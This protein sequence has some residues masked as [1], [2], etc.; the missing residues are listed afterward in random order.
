MDEPLTDEEFEKFKF[1]FGSGCGDLSA[2]IT[3]VQSLEE[4]LEKQKGLYLSA[5]KG[6][7][8]MRAAL[9][10]HR[11]ENAKLKEEL[12]ESKLRHDETNNNLEETDVIAHALHKENARLK[13]MIENGVGFEDLRDDH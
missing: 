5:V 8:D 13:S 4:E 3:K 12:E 6:R 2:V 10:M 7:Q 11:E 9:K 1:S